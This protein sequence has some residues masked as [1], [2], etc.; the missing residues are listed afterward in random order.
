MTLSERGTVS[1]DFGVPNTAERH[2][3]YHGLHA[4]QKLSLVNQQP[5]TKNPQAST[6]WLSQFYTSKA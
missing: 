5:Q 6:W 1:G 4:V 2:V 3:N